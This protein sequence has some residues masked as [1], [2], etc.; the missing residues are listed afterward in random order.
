MRS[1]QSGGG[2]SADVLV[3][4]DTAAMLLGVRELCFTLIDAAGK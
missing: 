1:E 4:G 2:R 3:E